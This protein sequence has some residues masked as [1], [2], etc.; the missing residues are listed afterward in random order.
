[1]HIGVDATCWQN[2]RGYGRHARALLRALVRTDAANQ[3]TFCLDSTEQTESLPPEADIKWVRTSIPTAQAASYDGHRAARDLW[4]MSRALA[5]REFD[6]L[7]FPTIYSYVPVWSR[8]KKIV[9]IHDIIAETFPQW[10]QPSRIGQLFWNIKTAAGRMQADAIVTVSEYSRRGIVEKFHLPPTRVAVVGEAADPVFRVLD[11]PSLTPRLRALGLENG[12]LIAYVGGFA[13]HKN[14][15]ALLDAFATIASRAEMRDI[16]LV[17]VGE[18]RHEIFY[19][20]SDALAARTQKWGLQ[21]RVIFTGYLPDE[22][23]VALLNRATVF[24]LPSRMEG[25]GLPAVEAA[26][27]GCPVIATNASPLPALLG[28]GALYFDPRCT[29]ELTTALS[30]VLTD[31]RLREC[32][33]AQGSA[34]AARLTW[35]AAAHQLARIIQQFN[36]IG[37][38][39]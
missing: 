31:E 27:C 6:L 15:A 30:A 5:T 21:E 7:L 28:S 38:V 25:F 26:A 23:L 32:L 37:S 9:M 2:R 1:M 33:R 17:L 16:K 34:A 29:D 12:R 39:R 10:T 14:L 36:P 8:A 3:Y 35:D 20:E 13:P 4:R 19:G 24:V 22:E 11:H 18:Y